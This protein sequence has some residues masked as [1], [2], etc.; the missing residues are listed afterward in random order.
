MNGIVRAPSGITGATGSFSNLYVSG[1]SILNGIVRAPS[2]ITGATGSFTTCVANTFISSS[3]YR[4]KSNIQPLLPFRTINNLKP[5]E[6]DLFN[7]KHDMGFIA[8]E[9]QEEFPFLV[10]GEKDGKNT[11]S[12]NYNGF[13]A[14]IVKELQDL[15]KEKKI[16]EERMNR[17]ENFLNLK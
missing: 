15:K 3:D 11:Q 5:V 9:V 8:H 4:L 2:G 12:I 1:P 16:L 14:L 13:I 17:I 10:D 7:T 6:Y